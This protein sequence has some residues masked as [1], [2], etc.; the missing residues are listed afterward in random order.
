MLGNKTALGVLWSFIEQ[1]LRR[2]ISVIVTL[3]LAYFLTPADYGLIAMI[4]LFLALGNTLMESGFKQALIRKLELTE[5]DL[6][7]VFYSNLF[8][9]VVAYLILYFIALPISA[10][11]NEPRLTDLIRVGSLVLIFNAFQVVQTAILSKNMKFKL[12]LRANFP[13]ALL[14]GGGA[15]I[16]AYLNLGVWALIGQML[17]SSVLISIFLWLQSSW[18]PKLSFSFAS[19]LEMY[20]YGYKLF[21]SSLLDT[22]YK[23]IFVLVIAK[24]FSVSLAGLYFF[25]DRVKELL[26]TQLITSI[27][28]VTFPALSSIQNDSIR[29]K[30]AYKT[31]MQVMTFIV[32]PT[33]LIFAALAELIFRAFLPEKWLPSVAYLQLMCISSL[34]IPIISINLNIIKIKGFSGWYLILEIIKKISGF[35]ALFFTFEYGVSAILFGQILSQGLNYYPSVY[36]SNKLVSY[37]FYQQLKDFVPNLLLSVFI[38]FLVWSMQFL[39]NYPPLIEL[40]ML[41]TLSLAMFVGCA[42]ILKLE[43][44]SLTLQMIKKLTS[45]KKN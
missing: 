41:G 3:L 42:F 18:R 2:G 9:S 44:L 30:Q 45:D 12:L 22:S 26:V 13:A 27:Q 24:V 33:L 37:S 10:Y 38:A 17:L 39:L 21:L 35:I 14:S 8:L 43:S 23:N 4:V 16:L 31:I 11:Y 6:N 36:F 20:N 32:F 15:V 19:L 7:T 1:F 28:T 25:A 34:V 29:L 40:V 5:L